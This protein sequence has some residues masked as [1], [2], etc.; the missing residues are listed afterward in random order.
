MLQMVKYDCIFLT[1]SWLYLLTG[2]IFRDAIKKFGSTQRRSLNEK[3]KSLFCVSLES[4]MRAPP[5]C[6]PVRL[7]I[8]HR[9]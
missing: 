2:S 9:A 6:H 5:H 7:K 3:L 8:Q 1:C 4:H